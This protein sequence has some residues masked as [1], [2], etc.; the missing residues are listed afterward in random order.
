MKTT[1]Q[2]LRETRLQKKLE[3][4]DV[5]RVTKIRTDSL[6]ILESDDYSHLPGGTVARGFIRNYAKFLGLNPDSVLAVFRRD[7]VENQMGQIVPRG[8]VDPVDRISWWTPKTTILSGV[9]LL[10]V[11]FLGY[12]FYQYQ[13]LTGPPSLHLTTPMEN[14]V[15]YEDTVEISGTTDPE[16]TLSINSQP[17]VLEKGGLFYLRFPIKPGPNR[18]NVVATGKSGRTT[19]VIRDVTLTSPP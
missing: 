16:A 7:F 19:T 11:L 2:I 5:A 15:T 10:F 9:G 8:M 12:L 13:N 14:F 17:V 3:L 1:G 18:L 4:T 6:F